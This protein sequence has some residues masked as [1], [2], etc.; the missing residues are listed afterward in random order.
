MF[1][2]YVF[3]LK[4]TKLKDRG[5]KGKRKH[6]IAIRIW[7]SGWLSFR[8]KITSH[9]SIEFHTVHSII[10]R[11]MSV[12]EYEYVFAGY[13]VNARAMM[14]VFKTI[15][16]II[17]I[18]SFTSHLF[19]LTLSRSNTHLKQLTHFRTGHKSGVLLHYIVFVVSLFI[20]WALN[21]MC[22]SFLSFI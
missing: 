13:N 17:S 7:K 12:C 16:H 14:I 8:Q 20:I 21:Q 2:L 11:L 3:F 19:T 18:I 6:Y 1:I 5:A 22:A 9:N 15:S 10:I 4:K